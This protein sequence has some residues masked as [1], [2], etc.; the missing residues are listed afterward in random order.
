MEE[1]E[2]PQFLDFSA[3]EEE[4]EEPSLE[5][6]T[7]SA[8]TTTL[9]QRKKKKGDEE[10]LEDRFKLRNGKEVAN[11]NPLLLLLWF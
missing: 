10:S 5:K 1:D 7:V 3:E 6:E 11:C 4:E 8:P 9:M 2:I